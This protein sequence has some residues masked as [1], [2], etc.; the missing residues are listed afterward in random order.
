MEDNNI[1]FEELSKKLE[2]TLKH[3]RE[4]IEYAALIQSSLV[5]DNNVFRKYF[6]EYFVIWH[7]K[8]IVGGDIYLFNELRNDDEC[9]LMCIDCTGHG[10]PGAFV[11]MLVKSIESQLVSEI[12]N[13]PDM[14]IHPSWVLQFFNKR[15]K[16]LLKQDKEQT[17]TNIG[18][19]GSIIYYNKQ[20]N[21]IRFSGAESVGFIRKKDGEII[22]LKG[23]RKSVGYRQVPDDYEYKEIEIPVEPGMKLFLTTDGYI[24]QNGGAKGFP[25]GKKRFKKIIEEYGQESMADLQEIFMY[26]M[27]SYEN[28]IEDNDRNDDMTVIGVTFKDDENSNTQSQDSKYL[29][30]KEGQKRVLIVDD[31]KI[32]RQMVGKTVIKLG[33]AIVGEASN[34]NEGFEKYK[35]L[36]PDLVL[37]DVEMPECDGHEMVKKI[38]AYDN[39]A[40]IVMVTSVVNAQFIQKIISEGAKTA[41]KKPITDEKIK[42][43]LDSLDF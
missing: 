32:S 39:Q 43:V 14:D 13:N 30:V 31:S 21:I 33:H 24:D 16:K 34:G 27:S 8:D 41:I 26:E 20:K 10:V 36:K 15:M 19:D 5:P 11:T 29:E 18:F 4:S 35:E 2:Q 3:T 17:I 25:F 9:L 37:S 38:I 7:P 6:K 23:D 42:K 28:A 1:S 40:V 22:T 12:Y